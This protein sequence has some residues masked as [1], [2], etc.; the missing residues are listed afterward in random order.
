MHLA[1]ELVDYILDFLHNDP[2]TLIKASLVSRAWVCRT[3]A[4]LCKSLK[5]TWPKFLSSNS[6]YLTPLCGYVKT[7]HFTWPEDLIDPSPVFDCFEQSEP[8]TLVIRSCE[9]RNIDEQTIRRCF[10]RFPCESIT[11]LELRE[12]TPTHRTLLILL[13]LFPN[14]DDLAISVNGCYEDGPDA[15]PF[16]D[17]DNETTQPSSPPSFRGRF[18]FFDPPGHGF[19]GGNR[20]NLLRTIATLPHQFEIVSL[21]IKTQSWRE[22]STFLRSC[23]GTVRKLFVGLP[24]RKSQPCILSRVPHAQYTNA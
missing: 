11:T 8:H 6:S 20:E 7:L 9:L 21:D 13:S 15:G 1:Q 17:G 4:H 3:R 23:L 22:I 12:I 16:G 10:K 2:K 19:S 24:Y 14:V 18:K 5:I